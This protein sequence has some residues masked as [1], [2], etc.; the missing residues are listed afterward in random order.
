MDDNIL[1]LRSKVKTEFPLKQMTFLLNFSYL[2]VLFVSLSC[3]LLFFTQYCLGNLLY[4]ALHGHDGILASIISN[5]GKSSL[6]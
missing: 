3:F 2:P 1:V 6:S 4:M 5:H